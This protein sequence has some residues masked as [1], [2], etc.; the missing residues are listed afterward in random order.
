KAVAAE[1]GFE[2]IV[3]ADVL[4]RARCSVGSFYARFPSRDAFL[5]AVCLRVTDERAREIDRF[6]NPVDWRG[7]DAA[8]IVASLVAN[9]V[10]WHRR[11]RTLL[12]AVISYTRQQGP[13]G[14]LQRARE[15]LNRQIADRITSLLLAQRET[16]DHP[17]P[18]QAVRFALHLLWHTLREQIV[19]AESLD[20][21][22]P[23]S[24]EELSE[25]LTRTL[26]RYF[27]I[28]ASVPRRASNRPR[29]A[30]RRSPR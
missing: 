6:F 13:R 2:G 15:G 17:D 14:P 26:T 3:L 8:T 1:Q 5:E 4:A 25:E 10:R 22:D 30:I 20:G 27:G 7:V 18:E 19:F 16:I 23:P 11:G 28:P 9:T 24:D 12:R 21:R 29:R